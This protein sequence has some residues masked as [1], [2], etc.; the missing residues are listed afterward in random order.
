MWS[1]GAKL[2]VSGVLCSFLETLG[3]NLFPCHFQLLE[4]VCIFLAH[5]SSS[6]FQASNS[7]VSPPH[8]ATLWFTAAWKVSMLLRI[9]VIGS[10]SPG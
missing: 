10:D 6:I 9:C 8:T 2:K 7:K 4:D 3:E 5:C 1:H